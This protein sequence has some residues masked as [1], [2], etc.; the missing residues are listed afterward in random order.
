MRVRTYGLLLLGLAGLAPL[1]LY[2]TLAVQRAQR[3]TADQ[4]R[5]SNDYLAQAL[6]QGILSHLGHQR[7][8]LAGIGIAALESKDP[9][10]TLE[11]IRLSPEY[12]HLQD[13]VVYPRKDRGRRAPIGQPRAQLKPI[14]ESLRDRVAEGAQAPLAMQGQKLAHYLLMAQP[15]ML[16]GAREGVIIARYD[17]VGIW[18]S[19]REARIGESG[20]ARVVSSEYGTLAHGDTDERRTVFMGD[21]DD[22]STKL[23]AAARSQ[24]TTRTYRGEQVV[25]SA[26]ELNGLDWGTEHKWYVLVER[27]VDEAFAEARAIT[28]ELII[29]AACGLILVAL[30]GF[31]VG[32]TLVRFLERLRAHTDR[33]ANDLDARFRYRTSLVE[34]QSLGNSLDTMAEELSHKREESVRRERLTTF[35]RVAAGLAHDLRLPIEAVRGACDW[36]VRH[37]EDDFAHDLLRKVNRRELPRLKRFVDDLQRLAREGDLEMEAVLTEPRALAEE[38]SAELSRAPKWRDVKFSVDGEVAPLRLDRHL[39]RRAL[40][41]LAS[42]AADAC[43]ERGPGNNVHIELVDRPQ[44][45]GLDFVELK[46]SDTGNGIPD[47]RLQALEQSDFYSTKRSTGVGLGLSVVRQVVHSHGGTLQIESKVGSGSVFTL[48]LPR[49]SSNE[50]RS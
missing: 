27:S 38:I 14:Y 30:I 16:A 50:T 25:V 7:E 49:K 12:K 24:Q 19:L 36:V 8:L 39:V 18:R 48:R 9:T 34:L 32:R 28:L 13:I 46:V 35:S 11:G 5:E 10:W 26:V 20:F 23:L 41:N 21:T 37:P 3:A 17:M 31:F 33:L 42:N 22:G 6:A 47:D 2:G 43:V 45:K 29:A 1:A 40:I 44:P 15:V 4:V